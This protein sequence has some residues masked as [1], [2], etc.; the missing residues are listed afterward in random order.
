MVEY[1]NWLLLGIVNVIVYQV[2]L[3]IVIKSYRKDDKIL[4]IFRYGGNCWNTFPQIMSN[5]RRYQFLTARM[6]VGIKMENLSRIMKIPY[7]H[8]CVI[9]GK[10]KN[11]N[12]FNFDKGILQKT[13]CVR[14]NIGGGG[15]LV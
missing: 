10:K 9:Y 5:L 14:E 11:A 7:S 2:F 15:V 1:F 13:Y 12:C 8:S 6:S 3:N 4:I